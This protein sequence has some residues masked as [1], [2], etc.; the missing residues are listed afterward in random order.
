M[1]RW[2]HV[3]LALGLA[4]AWA[5]VLCRRTD[6]PA[7]DV[8]VVE[9]RSLAEG[10]PETAALRSLAKRQLAREAAAG[11]RSLLEV[12]ALFGELNRLPPET[13]VVAPD[14]AN[15]PAPLPGGTEE[16]RLCQQVVAFVGVA[17][18]DRPPGEIRSA[19]ARLEAEFWRE[20]EE[21]GAV[22]LPDPASLTPVRELLGQARQAMTAAERQ[23]LFSPRQLAPGVE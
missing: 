8:P 6:G 10:F 11:R 15:P 9:S 4:G 13:P 21:R 23:A 22:R 19:V 3:P 18:A 1:K 5:V 14:P 7:E 20:R 17:L 16:E 12:A 2:I